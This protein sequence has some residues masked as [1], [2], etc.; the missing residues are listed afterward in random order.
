MR[1]S[2]I[3]KSVR[4]HSTLAQKGVKYRKID[5]N[6]SKQEP[7]YATV[8]LAAKRSKR[9]AKSTKADSGTYHELVKDK[10]NQWEEKINKRKSEANITTG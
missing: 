6:S 4:I 2:L 9:R 5:Y 1:K 7:I 3:I 10:K 8:D